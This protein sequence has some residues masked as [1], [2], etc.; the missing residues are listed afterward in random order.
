M[1]KIWRKNEWEQLK[2]F[3]VS[4]QERKNVLTNGFKVFVFRMFDKTVGKDENT[5]KKNTKTC[6]D[7]TEKTTIGC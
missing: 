4:K 6:F 2:L 1:T 5:G 7:T 3:P